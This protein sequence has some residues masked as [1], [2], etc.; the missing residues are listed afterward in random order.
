MV[1]STVIFQ[2]FSVHILYS[3]S[4]TTRAFQILFLN[5]ASFVNIYKLLI[6]YMYQQL[7]YINTTMELNVINNNLGL[8]PAV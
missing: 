7:I 1:L 4:F 5:I 3:H 8:K 2:V 6:T